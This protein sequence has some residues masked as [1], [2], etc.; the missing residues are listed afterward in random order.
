MLLLDTNVLSAI[1]QPEPPAGVAGLRQTHAGERLVTAAI[2]EAEMLAGIALMPASRR[3][4]ELEKE[5]HWLFNVAMASDVL[6]FDRAAAAE[7][8]VVFAQCRRAGTPVQAADMMIAAIARVHGAVVVTRNARHFKP[9]GV[10]ILDPWEGQ[11]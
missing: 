11:R 3:R 7:Y 1:V 4:R 2:C 6:P 10:A 5:A 8:A 9:C